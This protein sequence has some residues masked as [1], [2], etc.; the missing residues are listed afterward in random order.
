M[1][2]QQAVEQP[3][4]ATFSY[5]R[6]SDPHSY[7]PGLLKV[8]GRIPSETSEA[9]R[10]MGHDIGH[11]PDWEWLAG[12]VCVIFNDLQEGR[13]EGGADPRRP[14]AVVGW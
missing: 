4:F 7:D 11:W 6:S 5:P 1:T 8:E 9:L 10:S 3:R 12:A 13:M 14:T 2:P